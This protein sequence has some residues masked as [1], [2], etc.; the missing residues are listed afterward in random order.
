M[1]LACPARRDVPC[2]FKTKEPSS[3]SLGPEHES[4]AVEI[5]LYRT[6]QCANSV[7]AS[8]RDFLGAGCEDW[9]RSC[10]C[11]T[12]AQHSTHS[13]WNWMNSIRWGA[14]CFIGSPWADGAAGFREQPDHCRLPFPRLELHDFRVG[15]GFR[16]PM[17]VLTSSP[18]AAPG[19]PGCP[20][21]LR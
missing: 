21:S 10:H 1:C 3:A 14:T 6:K 4:Q 9:D 16:C 18:C 11:A 13:Q 12:F 20:G 19:K 5:Q 15:C 17:G 8:A 7:A 2:W